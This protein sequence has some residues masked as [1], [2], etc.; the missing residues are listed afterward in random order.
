MYWSSVLRISSPSGAVT[1]SSTFATSSSVEM[2]RAETKNH[3]LSL[4]MGPPIEA[5]K[6]WMCAMPFALVKFCARISSLTLL[7]C[8]L[9]SEPPTK[10]LPLTLLPPS[11]GIMFVRRPPD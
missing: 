6:F 10:M 9:P 7:L 3:S 4:Q 1:Y 5:L 2:W 11:F 8:Q